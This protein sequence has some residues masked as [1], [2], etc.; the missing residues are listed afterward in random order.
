VTIVLSNALGTTARMW[1]P[2]IPRLAREVDVVR[3]DHTPRETVAEL[4]DDVLALAADHEIGRFDFCGL[5]LGA[6]VGM[7]LAAEHPE[8]IGRL[9]LACTSARFGEPGDWTARA[10]LVRSE[11]MKAVAFDAL[12][13]WFTPDFADREPFL[14][15][16]LKTPVEDYA[17][18]LL[19]IGSFDFRSRL[20]EITAP[21]LVIAGAK[22]TATTP[23]DA[24]LIAEGI[25]S[26]RLV[27]LENAA[28]L[29]NVE[30]AE[31]F[32]DALLE[33]LRG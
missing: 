32:T 20:Q 13:K 23:A 17:R 22:D 1:D 28:H 21:T 9:V 7:T 15:M 25:P 2:Q 8:R 16:Q 10:S 33:H 14:E 31:A 19:A 29:A 11:G 24:S 27:V 5:S 4:A 12:E 30:Q 6:M 26:A 3:Y 18:G